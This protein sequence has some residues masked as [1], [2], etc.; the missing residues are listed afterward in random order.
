MVKITLAVSKCYKNEGRFRFHRKKTKQS[1]KHFFL[2][3]DYTDKFEFGTEWVDSVTAQFLKLKKW[4]LRKFICVECYQV[5]SAYVK[6]D[7]M[8]AI[9]PYCPDEDED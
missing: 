9:C 2:S 6:N 3:D 8:K 1:W 7:R 4:H 5:F